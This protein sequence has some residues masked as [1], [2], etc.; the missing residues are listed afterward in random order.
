MIT[1]SLNVFMKCFKKK[2]IYP[3]DI[4]INQ[5]FNKWNKYE[6][7]EC[8]ICKQS[9]SLNEEQIVTSCT[10]CN[11]MLHCGI[12]GRCIG[13][14]CLEILDNQHIRNPWCINCVPKNII[15]NIQNNNI[16]GDC[17][18]NQCCNDKRVP[19]MYRKKI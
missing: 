16:N 18:C 12:A 10:G 19:K 6:F 5:S 14:N 4:E 7:I 3:I 8:G 17:L 15:I 2:K 9:F 1:L 11:K 13:P